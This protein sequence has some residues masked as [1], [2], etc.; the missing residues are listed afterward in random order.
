MRLMR[1]IRCFPQSAAGS[2]PPIDTW[3]GGPT[4]DEFGPFWVVR[5]VVEGFVDPLTGY[6][7]DIR[8]LDGILRTVVVNS[9]VGVGK[10]DAWTVSRVSTAMGDAFRRAAVACPTT[11]ALRR[12]IWAPSPFLQLSVDGSANN[13]VSLTQ[14]YEFSAS[15]R[16]YNPD[17]TDEENARVFG[18][19]ANPNGHGHNYVIEVTVRGPVNPE[20]GTVVD[21]AE[22]SR[23]IREQVL[24]RF[25]HKYL[26]TDCIEFRS[27]NPTVENIATVIWQL[28]VGEFGHAELSVVRVWETPK[29]FAEYSGVGVGSAP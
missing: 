26:N 24:N 9:L 25:D 29:T 16:L 15:H 19:C 3:N 14:S 20:L 22:M 17:F 27:L 2:A 12:I 10:T 28:L 7:C 18:K 1:E 21:L 4:A 5:A 11:V 13:M 6:L 8:A 23:A